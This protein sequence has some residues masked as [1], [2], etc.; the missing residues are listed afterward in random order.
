[1]D[2]G[3]LHHL[4]AGG[5]IALVARNLV[6]AMRLAAVLCAIAPPLAELGRL[7]VVVGGGEL[8]RHLEARMPGDV[9]NALAAPGEDATVA[10]AFDILLWRLEGHR[11]LHTFQPTITL[12][13]VAGNAL[14]SGG[15][16]RCAMWRSGAQKF[17]RYRPE[18]LLPACPM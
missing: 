10:Q 17:R 13:M 15:K 1:A 12:V 18:D 7:V 2:R 14:A 3:H 16:G 5:E 8:D 11:F 4:D 6:D 9:G